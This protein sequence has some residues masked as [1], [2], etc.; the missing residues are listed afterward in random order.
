MEPPNLDGYGACEMGRVQRFG[1]R[2]VVPLIVHGR[3]WSSDPCHVVSP[4]PDLQGFACMIPLL[5]LLAMEFETR[6]YLPNSAVP[7]SD[8][9]SPLPISHTN[10]V[11]VRGYPTGGPV[12]GV[13]GRLDLSR[14]EHRIEVGSARRRIAVACARC[15]KRKIRCSGD[16]G[17]GAGCASCAM[18]N[19]DPSHCQFH[20]VGSD[21]VQ[22]VIDGISMAHSLTNMS[23]AN[24]MVPIYSNDGSTPYQRP[25]AT[26]QYPQVDTK[27]VYPSTWTVPYQEDISPVESYQIDQSSMYLP[28]PTPMANSN[29]YGSSYRW[30]HPVQKQSHHVQAYVDPETTYSASLPYMQPSYRSNGAPDPLSSM[31]PLQMNLPERPNM[32]Q[33][34]AS[35]SGSTQRLLPIP[36]PSP[37]QNSR[38]SFDL[39]HSQRLRSGQAIGSSTSD[40][41]TSYGKSLLAWSN[42]GEI[43]IHGSGAESAGALETITSAHVPA[44]AESGMSYLP[45]TTSMSSD[46]LATSLAPQ[47]PLNFS[48]SGLLDPMSVTSPATTYSNFRECRASKSASAQMVRRSSQNTYYSLD[49]DRSPKRNSVSGGSSNEGTLASGLRYQP[50]PYSPS[51]GSPGNK[52]SR[53]DVLS[54]RHP[55]AHR[56]LNNDMDSSFQA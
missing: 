49:S 2:S 28:D 6:R 27:S 29:V 44:I 1:A 33:Y 38:V 25:M 4:E 21:H 20:R 5:N 41:K 15:R 26:H 40:D 3:I 22:K 23:T 10:R 8:Y 56:G 47:V 17:N 31:N 39:E 50:L 19:V 12:G 51:Q 18:A 37:A 48:T 53:R 14:D 36:Q 42:D 54:T 16:P 30:N 35:G 24:G 9:Y 46:G 55:T 7:F 45:S 34:H 43:P 11:N 52:K 13:H 32:R